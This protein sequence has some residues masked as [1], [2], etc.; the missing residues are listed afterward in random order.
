LD[1]EYTVHIVKEGALEPDIQEAN[2]AVEPAR[3]V[4]D[5]VMKTR[6]GII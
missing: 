6:E 3:K 4:R 1:I 5:A 2:Q